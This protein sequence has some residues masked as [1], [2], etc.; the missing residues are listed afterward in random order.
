MLALAI[1]APPIGASV[2]LGIS[3]WLLGGLQLIALG[4]VGRYVGKIY[5]ETKR[6][7]RYLV[8]EY[9]HDGASQNEK[10]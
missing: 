9:L 2:W 8:R 1:F 6:R 3:L 10:A 4:I 7:P 5:L